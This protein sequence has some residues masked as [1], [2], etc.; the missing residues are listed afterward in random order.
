MPFLDDHSISIS[1]VWTTWSGCSFF[2]P[3]HGCGAG[4]A[5]CRS[6]DLDDR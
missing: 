5:I 4:I 3:G 6:R 1:C 2:T